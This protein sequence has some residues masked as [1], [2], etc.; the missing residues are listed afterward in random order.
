M[1]TKIHY[2][3]ITK[4]ILSRIAPLLLLLPLTAAAQTLTFQPPQPTSW[5][6]PTYQGTDEEGQPITLNSWLVALADVQPAEPPLPDATNVAVITNTRHAIISEGEAFVDIIRISNNENGGRLDLLGGSLSVARN[7]QLATAGDGLGMIMV[8]GGSIAVGTR[9]QLA[10][11]NSANATGHMIYR[12]GIIVLNA[13]DVGTVGYGLLSLEGSDASNIRA[14]T[15]FLGGGAEGVLRFVFDAAGAPLLRLTSALTVNANGSVLIDGSAYR[16]ESGTFMLIEAGNLTSLD[17]TGEGVEVNFPDN[18][19][20]SLRSELQKLYIDIVKTGDPVT[21]PDPDS[22]WKDISGDSGFKDS[23]TALEMIYDEHFPWI[24][25]AT[26]ESWLCVDAPRGSAEGFTALHQES[27]LW[28]HFAPMYG[29]YVW[30][31]NDVEWQIP[32][33]QPH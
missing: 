11:N 13:V 31:Y 16:G 21:Q 20:V 33:L 12:S 28:L 25:S 9:L 3:L 15:I 18:Y 27:G 23:A 19:E 14:G 2:T 5:F 4:T 30:N 29:Q 32:D 17:I 6:Q 1:K 24:Y 10:G 26:F 22:F 7:A 8:D